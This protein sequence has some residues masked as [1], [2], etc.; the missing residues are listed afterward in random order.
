MENRVEKKWCTLNSRGKTSACA[1]F[2][3]RIFD[4]EKNDCECTT[5]C[6][7]ELKNNHIIPFSIAIAINARMPNAAYRCY[8]SCKMSFSTRFETVCTILLVP[9]YLPWRSED[10]RTPQRDEFE[11]SAWTARVPI[12]QFKVDDVLG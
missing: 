4:W 10:F 3:S 12:Y 7:P 1:K 8:R 2:Y 5:R 6:W 9:A 11:M